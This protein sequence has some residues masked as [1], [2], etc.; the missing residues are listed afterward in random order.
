MFLFKTDLPTFDASCQRTQ[1]GLSSVKCRA[2][3]RK[4]AGYRFPT[5]ASSPGLHGRTRTVEPSD[6]VVPRQA[7]NL[8]FLGHLIWG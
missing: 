3:V 5:L 8:L 4:Q 6:P 1:P 7:I 2:G